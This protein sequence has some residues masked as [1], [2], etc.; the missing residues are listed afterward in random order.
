[1][2]RRSQQ[3]LFPTDSYRYFRAS[4]SKLALFLQCPSRYKHHYIDGVGRAVTRYYLSVGRSIHRTLAALHRG[5]GS[6]ASIPD[7]PTLR[8]TLEENW[9]SAGFASP[10]E[11]S[12]W[13]DES[14][15]MLKSFYERGLGSGEILAVEKEFEATIPEYRLILEA[16]VDRIDRISSGIEII[17]Y[18]VEIGDLARRMPRP[19]ETLQWVMYY[20]VTKD[21]LERTYGLG[22]TKFSF[23]DLVNSEKS[24]VQPSETDLQDGL[25]EI[26]ETVRR[27]QTA[28]RFEQFDPTANPFCFDCEIRSKCKAFQSVRRRSTGGSY[29][30]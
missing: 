28:T 5:I 10:G 17:D 12:Q 18:K 20:F 22:P 29:P 2:E 3:F 15:R 30:A 24:Y 19:E 11:E 13:I 4:Y 9:I 23:I 14:L 16:R 27:I 26:V 25:Q 7:L 6:Q 21:E 8:R 1:M